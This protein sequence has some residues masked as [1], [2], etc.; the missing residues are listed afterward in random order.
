MEL[1]LPK[2]PEDPIEP[3]TITPENAIRAIR[4][5]CALMN[6][7]APPMKLSPRIGGGIILEWHV[8]PK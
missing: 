5:A 8:E 2:I 1:E 4:L 3:M 6:G 7:E